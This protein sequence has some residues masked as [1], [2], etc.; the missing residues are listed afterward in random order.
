MLPHKLNSIKRRFLG[1][2]THV[3]TKEP[4]VSLTFDDGPHPDYTL[5]LIDILAKYR[6]RATFFM[7][8]QAAERNRDIVRQ[9]AQ[10]GHSIGNHTWGHVAIP[11]LSRG[12]R[13][14][15]IKSCQKAVFPYGQKL[16]RPPWGYQSMASRIDALLLGYHVVAWNVVAEDWRNHTAEVMCQK[17]EKGI[18]PGSIVLLHD[19]IFR[20]VMAD[21]QHNRESLLRT[22][23]MLLDRLADRFQFITVPELLKRGKPNRQVWIRIPDNTGAPKYEA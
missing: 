7:V 21:P 6:A 15:Q 9:V 2:I 22:V 5:R 23:D 12:E 19:A 13:R 1:T 14:T 18:R 10:G 4:I 3:V 16:F 8:G 11:S 17:L 20:S